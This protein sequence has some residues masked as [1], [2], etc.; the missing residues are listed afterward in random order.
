MRI[1]IFGGD[2][3][4]NGPVADFVSAVRVAHEQGFGTFWLP[5]MTQMFGF[6]AL[7]AAALAGREVEGIELG[8]AVVPV[9]PRHPV[10][11]AGQAVTTQIYTGGRFTLGIGLSHQRV[12]EGMFGL[13]YDRPA[14]YMAEYLEVLVPLV[15]GGS[16]SF[17]GD[18]I[19][20]E[21]SIALN[22]TPPVP[23]LLAALGP[24][25]LRLAGSV[26][27]GTITWMTGPKA[28]ATH[29]VPTIREASDA[30]GRPQPRVA[31]GLPI[32]V[33]HNEADARERATAMLA[34][35]GNLPSYRA[36]LDREGVSH[37]VEI[38]LIGTEASIGP[39]LDHL[40]EVGAT[41][42]VAWE[43]GSPEEKAATR[44]FLQSRLT[45]PAETTTLP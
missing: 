10:V 30:A 7:T 29:V 24:R 44:A 43:I 21:A 17:R 41:D 35:Y 31:V 45:E 16:V 20:G 40:A 32:S 34:M 19:T 5:Q 1:G 39:Q 6:D 8:T 27:D 15:H 23:V 36:M 14:R 13:S 12:I 3:L 25:M 42:L 4:L 2:G 9:Y 38:A 26:A 22:E 33:T 11:L 37:P 18:V 28:L